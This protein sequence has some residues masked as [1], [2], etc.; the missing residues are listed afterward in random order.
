M[1]RL[2]RFLFTI[3]AFVGF[4]C[5]FFTP[6]SQPE[7]SLPEATLETVINEPTDTPLPTET[8]VPQPAFEAMTYRD[9]E[10]GF[11]FDYPVGWAFDP[12]EHQ[13]RGY[14]IQ[15]YSWD[16]QPG[17]QIDSF[18]AG[19]TVLS[20]TLQLWDPKND[21]EAFINQ[22]KLAWDSSGT[23]ILSEEHI[24]LTGN[25]PAVQFIVQGADGVPAYFLMTTNGEDYLILSGSGDLNL[26]AEVAQTLRPIP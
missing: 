19:E 12:G 26:L 9:E 7:P 6:S 8:P 17:D 23:S 10:A 25:R 11:E 21:L 18:P 24:V 16:W 14:Y 13:S 2:S 15:F 1:K 4:A 22:R 20:I 3:F 5:S